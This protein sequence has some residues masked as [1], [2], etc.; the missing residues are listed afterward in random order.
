MQALVLGDVGRFD[1]VTLDDPVPGPGE[2]RIAVTASGICGS[3][4]G[5]FLGTDGLRKPG[6]VFGHE[7]VGAVDAYGP[8]V[9]PDRQLPTGT[10]VTANPLRSCGTC[11]I[12]LG[13]HGNVCPQRKLLGGHV[14]G[15]NADLVVVPVDAV[16]RVDHLPDLGSSVF[17][18]PTACALRAVGRTRIRAG[19]SALVLGAGPIGLLLLEVL[20]AKGVEQLFFTERVH[21]RVAA[22]EAGGAKRLSDR[23]EELVR[24]I[25][26]VTGGLGADAVFDAV[27]SADTRT[28]A[29]LAA[30]PGG[31]VCFVG[32]HSADGM[33][34]LRDLIRREVAC[35]TSF[36][37]SPAEFGTAVELLGRGDL[38]FRG[39][40]VHADLTA[41]QRWYEELIKGHPAGKVVLQ[42]SARRT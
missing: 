16:H 42:P 15:S 4:L 41:G 7:F 6:L 12:C 10:L 40:I 9:P 38:V 19:G 31:D 39:E 28:A 34:P 11:P 25:K 23:P 18:E 37:Y 32:L 2:V 1:V 3:E 8:D 20:R 21:G 26:D 22:A 24:Q 13:G 30:R 36:A 5:G 14:H 27:G 35:T 29:T 17:A 33:L